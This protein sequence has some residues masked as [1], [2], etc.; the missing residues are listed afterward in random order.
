[1]YRPD[2]DS[3]LPSPVFLFIQRT[4]PPV[5]LCPVE[6]GVPVGEWNVGPGGLP[7]GPWSTD[8]PP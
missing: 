5:Y 1:M 2:M 6:D 8:P 4:S 3:G 7:E